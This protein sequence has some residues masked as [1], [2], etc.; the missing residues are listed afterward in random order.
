[1]AAAAKH[2]LDKLGI[3]RATFYRGYDRY[4][5]GGVEALVDHQSRPDRIRSRTPDGVHGW[6]IDLPLGSPE[7]SLRDLAGA[8]HRREQVFC[9]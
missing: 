1:M 5:E 6:I 2:T 4:Q 8:I 9:L 3:P 7:L